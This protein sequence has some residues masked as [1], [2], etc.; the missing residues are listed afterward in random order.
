[1]YRSKTLRILAGTT[2]L[3]SISLA[4]ALILLVDDQTKMYL[5]DTPQVAEV[6]YSTPVIEPIPNT[7]E[8]PPLP[9]IISHDNVPLTFNIETRKEPEKPKVTLSKPVIQNAKPVTISAPVTTPRPTPSPVRTSS[10]FSTK[11]MLDA[12]N[13]VRSQKGLAPLVWSDTLA[14]SSQKWGDKLTS[15]KCDFYHD[16]DSEY[17]E[18]LFWKWI[19]DSNNR[20]LIST[21][22]DAVTWWADEEQI[23]N[24]TKN[25][26]KK[27]KD[28]GH[29]TQIVWADTTEVGCSV[30]TC[31]DKRNDNTQTDFWVCR[32]NPPGNIEGEW[33][34]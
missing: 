20:G 14:Q 1:M 7:E 13:A 6:L 10:L 15:Q 2:L 26:C 11:A 32:Y 29:Y 23:Y 12:H 17:G 28:C 31:F 3:A 22:E 30:S 8:P 4:I 24:H 5:K 21:P 27:G 19:S 18:N 33:P 9:P 34:Y 16:P 25:T